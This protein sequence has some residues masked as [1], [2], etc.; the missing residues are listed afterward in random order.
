M[1]SKQPNYSKIILGELIGTFVLVFIGI[2]SVAVAVLYQCL[3][4]YQIAAIWT[5][6]VTL[7][8]YSSKTWSGAKA[9]N[10][11]EMPAGPLITGPVPKLWAGDMRAP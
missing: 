10:S 9:P 1:S 8:I 3:N 4:L 6:A 11:S 7:G 5:A 2:G